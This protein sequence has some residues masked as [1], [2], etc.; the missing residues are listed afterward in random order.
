MPNVNPTP[1]EYPGVLAYLYVHDGA[2]AL[3]F[4]T[5]AFGATERMR[6]PMANGKVGHAELDLAGGVVMLADEMPEM[7][8]KSPK[9]LGGAGL[10]LMFYVADVDAAFDR[11]IQAGGTVVRAVEDQFYG[12]RTGQLL[13]PF[14]HTWTLATHVRDVSEEEMAQAMEQMGG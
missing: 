1:P 13:D 4:Y 9:T 2:A 10:S 12:D 8:I 7:D 3:D 11:A 14:G 6:M 5:R